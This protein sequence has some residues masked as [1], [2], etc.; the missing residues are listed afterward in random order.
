MLVKVR[1]QQKYPYVAKSNDSFEEWDGEY[2]KC[3]E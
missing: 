3:I 2:M 1:E